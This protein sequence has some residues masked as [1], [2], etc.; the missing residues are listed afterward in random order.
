M[1]LL[2]YISIKYFI[3]LLYKTII[4]KIILFNSNILEMLLPFIHMMKIFFTLN[5]RPMKDID[6]NIN[7]IDPLTKSNSRTMFK[8]NKIKFKK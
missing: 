1:I 5:T 6:Y 7:N 8:S 2:F 3:I 4:I